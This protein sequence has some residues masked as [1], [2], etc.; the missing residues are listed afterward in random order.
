MIAMC[1]VWTC[2]SFG[3][4]LIGFQTKYIEGNFFINNITSSVSEMLSYM[5]AGVLFHNFGLKL[6]IYNSFVIAT[7]GMLCLTVVKTES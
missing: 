2:G 3:Y 6:T 4:Y 7:I 5:L 1:S